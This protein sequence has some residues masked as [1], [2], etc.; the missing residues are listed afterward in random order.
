MHKPEK[1]EADKYPHNPTFNPHLDEARDPIITNQIPVGMRINARLQPDEQ[2][3]GL[4]FRLP[5][6]VPNYGVPPV[7]KQ[8]VNGNPSFWEYK[9][10]VIPGDICIIANSDQCCV[11]E[12]EVEIIAAND[13]GIIG[14]ATMVQYALPSNEKLAQ[15]LF[16]MS[17]LREGTVIIH[18]NGKHGS[19]VEVSDKYQSHP[20]YLACNP[21]GEVY[22]VEDSFDNDGAT[23]SK[24]ME[25]YPYIF[26]H[27]FG[28]TEEELLKDV[29]HFGYR[30]SRVRMSKKSFSPLMEKACTYQVVHVREVAKVVYVD[31]RTDNIL[32]LAEDFSLDEVQTLL[33]E[34]SDINRT[35][36]AAIAQKIQDDKL[37][38]KLMDGQTWL[39]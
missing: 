36:N 21:N 14:K 3:N 23:A 9:T 38:P 12:A 33:K 4:M 24:P 32:C 26:Q 28:I 25:A 16:H 29:V 31:I 17:G 15:Y 27:I 35:A 7:Y 39:N 1:H 18:T 34:A 11:G 8:G 2:N 22:Q 5:K 37:R 6:T 19:Y 30:V 10:T 13:T 20:V